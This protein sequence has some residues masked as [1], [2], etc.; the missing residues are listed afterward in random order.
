MSPFLLTIFSY[1][2]GSIP[3]GLLVARKVKG[4]DIRNHGSHSM[5]ATNVFRVVGKG[6]GI[7]VLFLDSLKG[8]L[9]VKIPE[10]WMGNSVPFYVL[11]LCGLAAVLG[12][13]FPVWLGFRG[14]KGIAT[15]LGV[16]LALA[17]LPTIITFAL[18]AVVF[19]VTRIISLSSLAATVFFPFAILIGFRGRPGFG[20]LLLISPLVALFIFYTHRA[21]IERLRRG[22]EKKLF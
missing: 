22:E 12:H 14:G 13:T 2:L 3:F 19:A 8:Y 15:S 11:I 10:L 5:G 16:F 21:N 7:L 6:W 17:F 20:W 18:W 1:L 9:A 4:I